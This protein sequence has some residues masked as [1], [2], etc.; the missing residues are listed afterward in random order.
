M[1]WACSE[2]TF[3]NSSED[4]ICVVCEQGYRFFSVNSNENGSQST[5]DS[6]DPNDEDDS[7][8][9]RTIDDRNKIDQVKF[10]LG[11]S[12]YRTDIYVREDGEVLYGQQA[13]DE[14]KRSIARRKALDLQK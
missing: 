7:L 12:C 4:T 13:T 1:D 2:C 10:I 11:N 6:V 14:R 5:D 8:L 3:I 9:G